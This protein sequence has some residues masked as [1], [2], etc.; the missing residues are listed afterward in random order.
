[1]NSPARTRT[2][3]QHKRRNNRRKVW[4]RNDQK[5]RQQK[6][7][8]PLTTHGQNIP[9]APSILDEPFRPHQSLGFKG[10]RTPPGS[11][12]GCN[13]QPRPEF[14]KIKG[15][16]TPPGSPSGCDEQSWSKF[17]KIKGPGTPPCSPSGCDDQP[18]SKFGSIKGPRTPPGSPSD[19]NVVEYS[20]MTDVNMTSDSPPMT[21]G[22]SRA[23]SSE[24]ILN[25]SMN[26]Y[27]SFSAS[28]IK[29]PAHSDTDP[30]D[31]SPLKPV[32][33]TQISSLPTKFA[34]LNLESDNEEDIE[35]SIIH[36]TPGWKSAL[37]IIT[38]DSS[39][40]DSDWQLQETDVEDEEEE[41]EV[42][43]DGSEDEETDTA[44]ED[45]YS[46]SFL[47]E[48]PKSVHFDETVIDRSQMELLNGECDDVLLIHLSAEDI[49]FF[50]ALNFSF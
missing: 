29:L 21:P 9:T 14:R 46:M 50:N 34:R 4:W 5:L 39:S 2:D 45:P 20:Y 19:S 42:V 13:E 6:D 41:E 12:S 17:R 18:R 32:V 47:C 37:Q 16:R 30:N 25:T 3:R 1:M 40:N 44:D 35:E 43:D 27:Y 28:D 7:L 24:D 8:V 10:P 36:S 38:D 33:H 22:M 26:L 31:A 23:L 11:P 48:D 49:F 15:P